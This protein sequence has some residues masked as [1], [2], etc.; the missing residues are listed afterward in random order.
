MSDTSTYIAGWNHFAFYIVVEIDKEQRTVRLKK[1]A[2]IQRSSSESS[3]DSLPDPGLPKLEV[4]KAPKASSSKM[5]GVNFSFFLIS[6]V[7]Q[8]V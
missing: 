6:I 2:K 3:T 8:H 5:Q 4:P 7:S 1:K